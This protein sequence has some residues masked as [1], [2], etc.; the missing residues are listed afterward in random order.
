MKEFERGVFSSDELIEMG[1]G[2]LENG[3]ETVKNEGWEILDKNTS[4]RAGVTYYSVI[5]EKIDF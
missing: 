3:I 1:H 5:R 2:N 4:P